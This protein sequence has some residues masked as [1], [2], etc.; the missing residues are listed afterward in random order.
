MGGF[1]VSTTWL[2]HWDGM[3]PDCWRSETQTHLIRNDV[4]NL[5]RQMGLQ[6][7]PGG[8]VLRGSFGT[9]KRELVR[10]A[11]QHQ[12]TKLQPIWVSG[13]RYGSGLSYGAIH[14]LL[15]G[16]PDDRLDSPLAVYGHLKKHFELFSPKPII[17]V[18]HL[19]L[20]DSLTTAV[21]SQLVSN[22]FISMVVIDDLVNEIPED[23]A[24]LDR[25]GTIEVVQ[26]NILTLAEARTQISMMLELN[27]S[28]LTAFRL[29]SYTAGSSEVLRAVVRDCQEA[30]LFHALE[31]TAVLSQPNIPI[32]EH[33]EQHVISRIER[34]SSS[35]REI[36]ETVSTSGMLPELAT[37]MELDFLYS[38][39]L[40]VRQG[41]R[42]IIPNPAVSRTVASWQGQ[43]ASEDTASL[44]ES[45]GYFSLPSDLIHE[46]SET[47][48]TWLRT[49]DAA[50]EMMANGV[51][52]DAISLAQN[53]LLHV[54]AESA[55]QSQMLYSDAYLVLLELL[56]SSSR[57]DEARNIIEDLY[58]GSET[59]IWETLGPCQQHL[60]LALIAQFQAR[61]NDLD[62]A[63]LL[64]SA[65]LKDIDLEIQAPQPIYRLGSCMGSTLKALITACFT[66]GNWDQCRRITQ[67]ILEG[68]LADYRLITFAETI[69]AVM[70][71]MEGKNTEA[72][73]IGIPLKL[74]VDRSGTLQEFHLINAVVSGSAGDGSNSVLSHLHT[75]RYSSE[76]S[77]LGLQE[78][79][80]QFLLARGE[81]PK[82][83]E[84]TGWAERHGEKLMAS[85]LLAQQICQGNFD[86]VPRLVALQ[87]GYDH[88][89]ANSLRHLALSVQRSSSHEI[90]TALGRLANFGYL[91]F[92]NDVGSGVWTLLN[93]GQ[94]R[95]IARNANAFLAK[96]QPETNGVDTYANLPQLTELTER[97]KFVA[98]AAASGFSNMEIAEQASVSVRTVEGHLYQVYSKL[99]ISKRGELMA[100]AGV[101]NK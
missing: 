66:L 70:L 62:S 77:P 84:L 44:W 35:Q 7:T 28:Y 37:E 16:L 11:F 74:Q 81:P 18:E 45:S 76:R 82:V 100:M 19:G 95:Q 56:L 31:G 21:L 33:T 72:R 92:A 15:T 87:D 48:M 41:V 32:G 54:N 79:I 86:L 50:F 75:A 42:W 58:P 46:A 20:I 96:A 98:A 88:R 4:Q 13:S 65:L 85:L 78:C 68:A 30:G 34:L 5:L 59:R 99:G 47:T 97:E 9:G 10:A 80:S 23:L 73:Q 12:D 64:V 40:L 63:Q 61:T 38:R 101:G 1:F 3:Q 83:R 43:Q 89:L 39:D 26:L 51:A 52:D 36:L 57:L 71:V 29:W 6:S 55:E 49:R 90:T 8:Y 22:G 53:F 91:T 2:N 14:F 69:H 67:M 24:V 17:I 94:K 25:T 27:V 93:A 60:A